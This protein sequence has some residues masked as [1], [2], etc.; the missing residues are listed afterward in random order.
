M[1]DVDITADQ[2]KISR[3]CWYMQ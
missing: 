2:L 1:A 3:T